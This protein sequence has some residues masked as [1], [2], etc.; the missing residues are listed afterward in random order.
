[1]LAG[2]LREEPRRDGAS[3]LDL[4][5]GSGLLAVVAALGGASRVVAIDVSRQAVMAT[6]IN[7]ALN[8]VRVHAMRGDLFAPVAGERFDVIVSN[9]PYLPGPVEHLPRAG[10]AR[11]WEGGVRG[12]VFIDRIC[13]EAGEHLR[14]GGA[15][16]LLHSSVCG[17]PETLTRLW[18]EG[19]EAGVVFRHRGPL[20]PVLRARAG[21]LRDQGLLADAEYED[22]VVIRA[23][24][25]SGSVSGRRS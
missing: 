17:I 21:W 8:G 12:R 9:P 18:R 25:V 13:D 5:S 19:L 6:R 16:L 2:R 10:A 4:C 24:R 1:M 7:A 3:V 14:P 22:V 20:G 15:L 11:A 23:Q